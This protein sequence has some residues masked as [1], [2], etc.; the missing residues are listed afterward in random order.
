M[1]AKKT[2]SVDTRQYQKALKEFAA[3]IKEDTEVLVLDQATLFAGDMMSKTPPHRGRGGNT[4]KDWEQGEN[5][6]RSD[7]NKTT[8]RYGETAFKHEEWPEIRGRGPKAAEAFFKNIGGKLRAQHVAYGGYSRTWHERQR[9]NSRGRVGKRASVQALVEDSSITQFERDRERR[10]ARVGWFK[11]WSGKVIKELQAHPA[12]PAKTRVPKWVKRHIKSV[13][14]RPRLYKNKGKIHGVSWE[15]VAHPFVAGAYPRMLN[16]RRLILRRQVR[17]ILN[18][19]TS[20]IN[21][22]YS[23]R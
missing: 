13:P 4:G 3:F 23:T 19:D 16:R 17:D 5:S 7:L 18:G 2:V 8:K 10:I 11:A 14:V 20:K 15:I 1:A 12:N 9:S 6:I 22:K 21:R